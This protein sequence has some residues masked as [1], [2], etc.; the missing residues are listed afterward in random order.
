MRPPVPDQAIRQLCVRSRQGSAS[1]RGQLLHV[2]MNQVMHAARYFH[3]LGAFLELGDLI[4]QGCLGLLHAIDK[5][6]PAKCSRGRRARFST[7]AHYWIAH[8]IRREIE[9]HGRTIAVPIKRIRELKARGSREHLAPIPYTFSLE[10]GAG[11]WLEDDRGTALA[12]RVDVND[13]SE[14]GCQVWENRRLV[15]RLLAALP[16]KNRDI[17]SCRYGL[18]DRPKPLTQT[19]V[20]R[21]LRLSGSRIGLLERT[22][23]HQL[24]Q[25]AA[26]LV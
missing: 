19:E 18:G 11:E 25:W 16:Q 14:N 2:H 24:R 23:I 15:E 22:A 6:N 1:A 10:P 21:K 26:N 4:Q 5:F 17:L 20:G 12:R 9:N 13:T 7:Y 8:Y 3:R